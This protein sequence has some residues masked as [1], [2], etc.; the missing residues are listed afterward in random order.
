MTFH[1]IILL[2]TLFVRMTYK[3]DLTTSSNHKTQFTNPIVLR[4]SAERYSDNIVSTIMLQLFDGKLSVTSRFDFTL[5]CL[6]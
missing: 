2:Y 4:M 6:P 3:H 1:C 5:N